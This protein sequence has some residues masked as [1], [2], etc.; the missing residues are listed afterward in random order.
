MIAAELPAF[1]A[2]IDGYT[3]PLEIQT[4]ICRFGF[5]EFHHPDLLAVLNQ[6]SN[7]RTLLSVTT[8]VLF[9]DEY[10]MDVLTCTTT[11]R[12]YWEGSAKE[13]SDAL[14]NNRDIP[15]RVKSTIEGEL[16][17]GDSAIKAG[18]KMK[19]MAEISD[20]RVIRKRV[21]QGVKWLIWDAIDAE[22][23]EQDSPF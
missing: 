15:H 14:L 13:W 3:T 4:G 12:R 11:G 22:T 1:A 2:F 7:E 16:G 6:N 19:M 18:K 21:T 8:T 20:G 17:F 9:N 10:R 5:D 23:E